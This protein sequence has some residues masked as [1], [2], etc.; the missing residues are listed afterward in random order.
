MI[1]NINVLRMKQDIKTRFMALNLAIDYIEPYQFLEEQKY[2]VKE[3][4]ESTVETNYI[5]K[6]VI[7]FF[8]SILKSAK[9]K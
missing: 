6:Y 9:A 7:N 1:N 3:M 4:I 2:L 5:G 8:E